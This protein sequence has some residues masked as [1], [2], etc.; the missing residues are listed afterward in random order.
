MSKRLLTAA[1]T[2]E[3]LFGDEEKQDRVYTMLREGILPGVRLGR[4]VRVDKQAL[5]EFIKGGGKA[6]SGGW[7]REA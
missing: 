1:E 4:Q 2:A 3:V 5:D 6:F 7:R